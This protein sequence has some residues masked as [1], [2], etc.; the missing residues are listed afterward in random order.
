MRV[1]FSHYEWFLHI[2]RAYRYL[3]ASAGKPLLA[4]PTY[5]N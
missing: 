5:F 2:S 4:K 1:K 3:A